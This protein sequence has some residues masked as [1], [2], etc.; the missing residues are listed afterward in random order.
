LKSVAFGMSDIGRRR[1]NNQDRFL[2]DPDRQV[3]A[4]ADGMGGHA[5]G[6]VASRIAIDALA[7]TIGPG[8]TVN[9]NFSPDEAASRLS[10]AV[11]EGNRRICESVL[12][13]DE[14]RGMGTTLVALV[15]VGDRAI[16][17]HVGD[18]RAYRL[19]H[20]ALERLTSDHSYVGEQVRL[21]LLTDEE[22]QRHPMRNIVTRAMGN[23]PD[24][25]V[26]VSE[27]QVRP[28]DLYL[29]C[30]DGLNSMLED[31]RIGELLR[32]NRHDPEAA[33]RALIEAANA[34][35]GEDNITVIVLRQDGS[36]DG[37]LAT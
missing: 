36:S 27:E 3:Y 19:R 8:S 7:D 30:S 35:G 32:H 13:H 23:R 12:T 33:C 2:V 17:G 18:S 11:Q 14:W 9:G 20:D 22:A 1:E 28:G 10:A 26:E 34:R 21:G 29:L 4:V 15:G 16:I 5:A 31:E 37:D 6:E 24:L 25:E